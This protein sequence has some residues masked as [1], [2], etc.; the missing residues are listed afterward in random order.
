MYQ[1]LDN[2][3]AAFSWKLPTHLLVCL[4]INKRLE[5]H[6][7]CPSHNLDEEILILRWAMTMVVGNCCPLSLLRQQSPLQ[8]P[9]SLHEVSLEGNPI[10]I[11]SP[12]QY[13][14][15]ESQ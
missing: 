4:G 11:D 3:D 10:S 6:N 12:R 5:A 1:L 9:F 2:G 7:V 8:Q 14:K 15:I 13:P